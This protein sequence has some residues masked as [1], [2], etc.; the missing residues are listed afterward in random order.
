M[1][2]QG[3]AQMTARIPEMEIRTQEVTVMEFSVKWLRMCELPFSTA[4]QVPTQTYNPRQFLR[5]FLYVPKAL[6]SMTH[7]HAFEGWFSSVNQR[8]V[9]E[10]YH[11]FILGRVGSRHGCT[12]KLCRPWG[13]LVLDD[14]LT[15]AL[16]L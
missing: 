4:N 10:C 9:H 15:S 7:T 13:P 3:C 14:H 2:S 5:R 16:V 11:S 12:Y 1:N 8:H 6:R